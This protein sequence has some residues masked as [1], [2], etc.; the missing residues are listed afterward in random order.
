MSN[1]RVPASPGAVPDPARR[2]LLAGTVAVAA[3]AATGGGA[4]A[5]AVPAGTDTA[6][7][8]LAETFTAALAAL[9]AAGRHRDACEQRYFAT[10]PDPPEA[11]TATGPLGRRLPNAWSWW[12]EDELEWL[13]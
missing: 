9:E 3:S 4:P 6:L 7:A 12:H 8:A 13:L 11:L 5:V 2:R 10:A 1:A